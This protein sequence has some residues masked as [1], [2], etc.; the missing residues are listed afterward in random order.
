VI[1]VAICALI[2]LFKNYAQL[3][4]PLLGFCPSPFPLPLL[5][6]GSSLA[7]PYC[8]HISQLLSLLVIAVIFISVISIV[9]AQS[10]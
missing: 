10:A 1:A 7:T 4:V 5:P 8:V 9:S 6:S 3:A 2:F